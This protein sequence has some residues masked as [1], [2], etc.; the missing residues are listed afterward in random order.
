ME[1]ENPK[2]TSIKI[3]NDPLDAY[4][5]MNKDKAL[6]EYIKNNPDALKK[7]LVFE[8]THKYF[9]NENENLQVD[10]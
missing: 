1:T 7:D 9:K 8:L 6:I 3:K 5:S 4:F 10:K 2:K